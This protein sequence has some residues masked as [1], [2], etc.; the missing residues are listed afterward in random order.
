LIVLVSARVAGP[1]PSNASDEMNLSTS[2]NLFGLKLP[3]EAAASGAAASVSAVAASQRVDFTGYFS[4]D[5][6]SPTPA[7]TRRWAKRLQGN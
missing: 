6:S 7:R 1:R 2:D 5:A 4:I 3:V